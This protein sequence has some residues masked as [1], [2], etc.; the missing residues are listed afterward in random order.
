M[1]PRAATIAA[2]RPA[3]ASTPRPSLRDAAAA[4][5]A[6]WDA[7]RSSALRT[8][9][10]PRQAAIAAALSSSIGI[11]SVMTAAAAWPAALPSRNCD[12][13]ECSTFCLDS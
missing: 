13:E 12:V 1:T 2:C 11:S 7:T 6:A 10:L 3:R 5:L 4:V 8:A 9:Y